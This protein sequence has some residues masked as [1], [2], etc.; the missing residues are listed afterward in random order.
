MHSVKQKC[1]G[2]ILL[3]LVLCVPGLCYAHPFLWK[4]T[5]EHEFFM[6][7]TIHLPD[8]RVTSLPAEVKQALANST[9]FYAELDLGEENTLFLRQSMWLP[10]EQSLHNLLPAENKIAVTQYLQ[11]V[12]PDLNLEFF[13]KQKIWVL[14][15]TL[16]V[17]EQQLKYPDH[18]PLDSVLYQYAVSLGLAT[19]ELETVEE[20]LLVF[21]SM[22]VSQ[23]IKFLNDTVD[24]METAL[25]D[26]K[27]FVEASIEAYLNGNIEALMAQL[28]AFM[29][30]DDVLYQQLIDRLINQRN[31]KMAKKMLSLVTNDPDNK[32]FFAI[33][34]GHF[35]GEHG[36]HSILM[37]QG[38]KI[39][40]V[41]Q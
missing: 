28:M 32:Y 3:L 40:T 22:S 2:L 20:Q 24:F 10:E 19:G 4:V 12:N 29:N 26:N 18:P 38:Y 35:C 17:L 25:R 37:E 39:Q 31:H 8:P 13:S 41:E 7:G 16:T 6:F 33:G 9:K 36:I 23:Q 30:K 27:S 14:A 15:V 11:S 34:A 5:G 21:D 1:N